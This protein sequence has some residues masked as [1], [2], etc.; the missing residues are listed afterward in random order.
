MYI[1]FVKQSTAER[2]SDVL[3]TFSARI[4]QEAYNFRC[5]GTGC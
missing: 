4:S 5:Q 2:L 3:E 1:Y